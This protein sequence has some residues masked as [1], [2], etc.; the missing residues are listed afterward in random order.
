MQETSATWKA[1]AARLVSPGSYVPSS[2]ILSLY[3]GAANVFES[4]T[5]QEIELAMG[6]DVVYSSDYPQS[7]QLYQG[8]TLEYTSGS[9][10]DPGGDVW[11]D[12]KATINGVD[13]TDISD[14]II[15]RALM[16]N[17][18]TVGNVVSATCRFSIRDPGVIPKSAEVVLSMRFNDGE[19]QSEWLPVGTFYVSKRQRDPLTGLIALECYDALLK[20]N[21]EAPNGYLYKTFL[22]AVRAIAAAIGV[23]VDART[24]IPDGKGYDVVTSDIGVSMNKVL[25]GIGAVCGGNWCITP[26]NE[27]RLVPLISASG[28]AGAQTDVIDVDGVIGSIVNDSTNTITGLRVVGDDG[29]VLHGNDSG[30]VVTIDSPYSEDATNI[31]DLR[32]T[33]IGQTYQHYALV[34]AVYDPAAELGDYVRAGANNE[35]NSVLYGETITLGPAPRGNITALEPAE[36]ADEYPYIGQPGRN[37]ERLRRLTALVAD[38]IDA[39]DARFDNLDASDIKAGIIHSS[40]YAVTTIPYI[41]PSTTTYPA[42]TLY[43]SNGEQVTS[44]FAIDFGAGQIYGGLYSEQIA[45]L[46]AAVTALQNALVYPKSAT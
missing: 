42:A 10:P 23:T 17:G 43:P 40:D 16:Q 4:G 2:Q 21:A 36:I 33:L 18:L 14:P 5:G 20:A 30:V 41:Y 31:R 11:L 13:Y 1:L 19:T 15:D 46:Q 37:D 39:I 32:Q 35:I 27:L 34:T 38:S 6:D 28:A 22:G 29:D 7:V 45:T 12:V 25:S 24:V 26:A 3:S 9:V 8:S 44:G